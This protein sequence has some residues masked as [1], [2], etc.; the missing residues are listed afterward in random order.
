MEYLAIPIDSSS[1]SHN[2]VE[3]GVKVREAIH[4]TP[5]RVSE[6]NFLSPPMERHFLFP[7]RNLVSSGWAMSLHQTKLEACEWN[8]LPYDGTGNWLGVYESYFNGYW[9]KDRLSHGFGVDTFNNADGRR[10]KKHTSVTNITAIIAVTMLVILVL[11]PVT[12]ME[13]MTIFLTTTQMESTLR[14]ASTGMR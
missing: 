2:F 3:V 9:E 1:R 13:A 6:L 14:I 12:N 8:L 4:G 11:G 5:D 7:K 10:Q